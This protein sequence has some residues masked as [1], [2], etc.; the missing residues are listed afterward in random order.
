MTKEDE[1]RCDP[2]RESTPETTS[3]GIYVRAMKDGKWESVDIYELDL[4]SLML[5]LR[6]RGGD[7]PWAENTVAIL[8]GH[9]PPDETAT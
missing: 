6:S 5:W 2:K 8:L 3:T 9:E 7:N 1:L 4:P